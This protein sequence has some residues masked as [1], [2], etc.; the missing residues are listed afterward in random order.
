MS[1]RRVISRRTFLQSAT[2]V[3]AASTLPALGFARGLWDGPPSE[4]RFLSEFGYGDVTLDSPIHEEQLRQTHTV[5]MGIDDDALLKPFRVMVGQPA[6]GPDLG[7]WYCYDPNSKNIFTSGFAPGHTFGQWIS[8]LS[9]HYAIHGS[10]ETRDKILRLNRLY[11]NTIAGDFYENTRFPAYTYDKLVCGL[12]DAHQ[13]A[14]DPDALAILG[15]TTKTA[16]PH[17][18]GKATEHGQN[19][20]PGRE[21]DETYHWDESYTLPENLLLAYHRGAGERYRTLGVQYLNEPFYDRL[22]R[23]END[24]KGRHAYSHVN[25]LCSAMQTYLT[26]GDEKYLRAAKNGFD[27]VQAQSFAT[28]GWGPDEQMRATGSSDVYDSL[29]KT[30]SSFETPC[31]S[32]AHFKLTRYL[33][34]VTRD[35]RYGD[36]LERV[37][38]NTV[39]GALPLQPD[40]RNFYY[41]DYNFKARKG[42]HDGNW[43]CCSGTLPQVVADYRLNCY[44]REERGVYVNLYVPSTLKWTQGITQIQL[45]Q[46]SEYPYKPEVE[47]EVT[48]SK[49]LEF[50]I[51]L[52]IPAWAEGASVAVNGKRET[53]V[54][55]TFARL[56]REWKSGDRIE[57]VLPM[58]PRLEAIDPQ[59]ADT[60]ALLNGPLVLFAVGETQPTVTREQL[61][62]AKKA[63][64]QS[65]QVDTQGGAMKLLPWTAIDDQPYSTYLRVS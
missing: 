50:S 30:H 35:P 15:Q 18:P 28:G 39:L 33:M 29:S 3:S 48:T 64:A 13:H 47:F 31:G 5:L 12:I 6:P 41:S 14:N 62:A 45:T 58:K 63:S 59:H 34:R 22:A 27:I 19:W 42:Y 52:R 36:S 9:R 11:A 55:G 57:L 46:R 2:V 32:Y 65:W 24:L 40:G 8:A 61:L 49:P 25:C 44:F 60:V 51:H 20:R 53:A 54:A 4:S 38:Y 26:V 7:G 1:S 17:L 16:M 43:A 10:R 56:Q 23:G 37:M 21:K